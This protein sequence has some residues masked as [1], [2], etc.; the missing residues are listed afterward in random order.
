M[1]NERIIAISDGYNPQKI[2]TLGNYSA[3]TSMAMAMRMCC[4]CCGG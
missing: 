3:L 4:C 1:T 2:N